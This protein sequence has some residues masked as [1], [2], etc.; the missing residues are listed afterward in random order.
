MEEKLVR[1]IEV[2][3]YLL[4]KLNVDYVDLVACVFYADQLSVVQTGQT[5]TRGIKYTASKH[6]AFP[7]S[8]NLLKIYNLL[9]HIPGISFYRG[10]YIIPSTNTGLLSELDINILDYVVDKVRKE[11]VEGII[12]KISNATFRR[13]LK[14]KNHVYSVLDIAKSGR[15][16]RIIMNY[17]KN[18]NNKQSSSGR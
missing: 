13:K 6:Y 5:V 9:Y 3:T 10:Y 18:E 2:I 11:E 17:I 15:A 8:Y 7:T 14:S 16:D 4:H 12:N 1:N